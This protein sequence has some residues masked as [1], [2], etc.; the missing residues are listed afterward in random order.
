MIY[1][2]LEYENAKRGMPTDKIIALLVSDM[3]EY[4]YYCQKESAFSEIKTEQLKNGKIK[5]FK[6]L[7]GYEIIIHQGSNEHGSHIEIKREIHKQGV[8]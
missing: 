4:E 6:E 3:G 2:A 7:Y 5:S 8:K 1:T